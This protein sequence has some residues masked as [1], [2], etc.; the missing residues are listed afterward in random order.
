VRL[1][2][3]LSCDL[4]NV[5]PAAADA[6]KASADRLFNGALERVKEL[7]A[8]YAGAAEPTRPV[9]ARDACRGRHSLVARA[10]RSVSDASAGVACVLI[11]GEAERGDAERLVGAHRASVNDKDPLAPVLVEGHVWSGQGE[12]VTF[13]EPTAPRARFGALFS[14]LGHLRW[15]PGARCRVA[16]TIVRAGGSERL[17]ARTNRWFSERRLDNHGA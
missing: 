6:F 4:A 5:P 17:H 9:E 12:A 15:L 1:N 14:S 2:V 11:V 16:R 10:A 3:Q 7:A 13:S 8:A